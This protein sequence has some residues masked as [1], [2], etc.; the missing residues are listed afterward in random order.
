MERVYYKQLIEGASIPA[1]IHNSS[2]FLIQMAVYEN[3]TVSCWHKSDL[4]QFW[5]DLETGW[6]VPSVPADADLSI[7]PNPGGPLVL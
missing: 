1:I 5:G 6:V 7:N 4:Q 2:Y 3:G